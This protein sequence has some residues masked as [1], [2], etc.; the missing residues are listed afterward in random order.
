MIDSFNPAVEI[1]PCRDSCPASIDV[2]VDFCLGKRELP[3]STQKILCFLARRARISRSCSRR[4]LS[5]GFAATLPALSSLLQKVLQLLLSSRLLLDAEL[6]VALNEAPK[7]CEV[8]CIGDEFPPFYTVQVESADRTLW[9]VSKFIF[10]I[11]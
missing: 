5:R 8:L 11:S 3:R 2:V 6:R 9:C 1:D 10:N 7:G 4:K